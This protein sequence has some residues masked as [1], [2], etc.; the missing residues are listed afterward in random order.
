MLALVAEQDYS[1]NDNVWVNIM[2][3]SLAVT[4]RLST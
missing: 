4:Q 2:I 3:G 1:F